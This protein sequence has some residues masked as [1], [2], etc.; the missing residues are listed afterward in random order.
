MCRVPD[1][2]G[3][4]SEGQDFQVS[5]HLAMRVAVAVEVSGGSWSRN[6]AAEMVGVRVAAVFRVRAPMGSEE[7]EEE[8]EEEDWEEGFPCWEAEGKGILEMA[9]R[10]GAWIMDHTMLFQGTMD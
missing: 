2:G 7:E 6:G 1:Q 10:Q 9:S 3:V 4:G 5:E 8:E